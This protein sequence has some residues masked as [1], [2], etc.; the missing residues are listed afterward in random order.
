MLRIGSRGPAVRHRQH[1][2]KTLGYYHGYLDGI[3]GS[4][5]QSAVIR[6][7]A[8]HGSR[9]DGVIGPI[10]AAALDRVTMR[11]WATL[12]LGSR[13]EMVV[14]VQDRLQLLGFYPG[15]IDGIFG[16]ATDR[17]VR[18]FQSSIGLVEDGIV[19]PRTMAALIQA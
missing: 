5:T 6:F 11:R 9:Q 12:H 16:P 13:G 14:L 15:M 4:R 17:A 3:F 2:L 7:Q 8:A 1:Q 18:A 10:T 19:G